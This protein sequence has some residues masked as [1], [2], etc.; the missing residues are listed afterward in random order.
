MVKDTA[1][2]GPK[3]LLA[4]CLQAFDK[5]LIVWVS[6]ALYLEYE[7]AIAEC[8]MLPEAVAVTDS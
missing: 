6:P 7:S 2:W 8:Y 5:L 4:S 1:E 3:L